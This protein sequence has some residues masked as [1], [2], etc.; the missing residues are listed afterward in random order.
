MC[1]LIS[2]FLCARTSTNCQAVGYYQ[3]EA[4]VKGKSST[5]YTVLLKSE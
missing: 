4:V 3:D 1:K 5:N 2:R